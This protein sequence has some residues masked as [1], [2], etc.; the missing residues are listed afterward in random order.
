MRSCALSSETL[1][2]PRRASYHGKTNALAARRILPVLPTCKK[3]VAS[4]R[5]VPIG[6]TVKMHPLP[7]N[8]FFSF[9]FCPWSQPISPVDQIAARCHMLNQLTISQ[10][11]GKLAA[12]E[13]SARAAL[14]AC[15]DRIG[16]VDGDIRAFLSYD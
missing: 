16:T 11:T 13:T 2:W 1:T 4:E 9:C 3:L 10:L 15:L 7:P 6:G 5:S 12:R 14:Q 8:F